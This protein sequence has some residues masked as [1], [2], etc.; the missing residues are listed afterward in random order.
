IAQQCMREGVAL[1]VATGERYP[2][3]ATRGLVP[4]FEAHNKLMSLCIAG[5][6]LDGLEIGLLAKS[7]G[8]ILGDR[9]R[10][11]KDVLLDRRD[12]RAQGIQ[13]PI[14]YIN[15]ID[16]DA[17]GLHVVEAIDQF[18]KCALTR[19][20]L[21]ANCDCLTRFGTETDILQDGRALTAKGNTFKNHF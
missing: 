17:P 16:Q 21:A 15:V 4:L 11:E 13:V 7:V 5:S 9:A 12:L 20:R 14:A 18:S 6:P 1:A 10:E 8:N 2:S 3:F 19:P